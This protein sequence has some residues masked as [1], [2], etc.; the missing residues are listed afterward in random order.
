MAQLPA[1]KNHQATLQQRPLAPAIHR[2]SHQ[3][4][5]LLRKTPRD[6][7][8]HQATRPDNH[9]PSPPTHSHPARHPH[10][11]NIAQAGHQHPHPANS[12]A[13][14]NH[15]T[16][17]HTTPTGA[18]SRP[19]NPS[20]RPASHSAQHAQAHQAA[21]EARHSRKPPPD[22]DAN[23]HANTNPHQTAGPVPYSWSHPRQPPPEPRTRSI[24]TQPPPPTP[25]YRNS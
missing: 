13:N 17:A 1:T 4:P 8:L 21:A 15:R 2:R 6:K 22:T 11:V 18:D 9:R 24:P 12:H 19:Y 7:P 25:R 3:H 20:Q 14:P 23:A 16:L 10:T 5:R